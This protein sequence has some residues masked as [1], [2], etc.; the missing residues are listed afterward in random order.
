MILVFTHL[1]AFVA[2]AVT[3]WLLLRIAEVIAF[4]SWWGP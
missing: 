3:F 1:G 4:R 2:G